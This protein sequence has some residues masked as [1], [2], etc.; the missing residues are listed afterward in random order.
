[1]GE[2]ELTG[3]KKPMD[4]IKGFMSLS[5]SNHEPNNNA[6][7]NWRGILIWV[8]L[9]LL[10]RW[11]IVEPRWIPSGSMLPTLNIQDRI[12]VEKVSPKI[13][14]LMGKDVGRGSVVVFSPPKELLNLGYDSDKALIKRVVGIPGD[15]IEVLHGQLI[16][17]GEEI[18]EE[19]IKEKINY[20]MSL[21][22]IPED[23]VWVLGDNRNN[24]LDSH[25]WG[26]L[27]QKNIIGTAIWRYWP[28]NSFGSIRFPT[29]ERRETIDR[30]A[31]RS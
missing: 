6:K 31:I 30:T 11:Q 16:R 14:R 7:S 21:I 8:A 20:E 24:S 19:W 26:F 9:A 1:M 10:I 28:L 3:L 5:P 29:P 15:K 2:R 27:P 4:A 25:I 22:T 17:N 12:L 13:Q 18:Q 23:R